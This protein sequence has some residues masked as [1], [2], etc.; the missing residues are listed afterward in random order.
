V[1][2]VKTATPA[3][4]P[5]LLRAIVTGDTMTALRLIRTAPAERTAVSPGWAW[6]P[7]LNI[8]Y[9]RGDT[10]LHLAARRANATLV[11][12]LLDKRVDPNVANGHGHRPLHAA[13]TCQPQF[14]RT[15]HLRQT[16]VIRM[17]VNAGADPNA[18]DIR[19]VAPL[20]TAVRVRCLASV[21]ALLNAGASIRARNGATGATPLHLAIRA[22]GRGGSGS[23]A[24]RVAQASIL[25]LLLGR[26][27]RLSDRD[28]RGRSVSA[29]NPGQ[30]NRGSQ[31]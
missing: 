4:L 25:K 5:P 7:R 22:T 15:H 13:V 11:R 24:A 27:A 2:G 29:W 1:K 6:L 31:P 8:G 18:R 3:Q 17:L 16:R 20:H 9:A 26:G 23:P 10:P 28:R 14:P 21:R 30:A 12:R 19:G